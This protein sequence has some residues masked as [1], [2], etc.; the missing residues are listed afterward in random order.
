MLRGIAAIALLFAAGGCA[1][2][3]KAKREDQALI[4]ACNQDIRHDPRCIEL[5]TKTDGELEAKAEVMRAEE[6][7]EDDA[8]SARVKK[9]RADRDAMTSTRSAGVAGDLDEGDEEGSEADDSGSSVRALSAADPNEPGSPKRLETEKKPLALAV[10]KIEIPRIQSAVDPKPKPPPP[11]SAITPET[12]L[13]A[14]ICLLDSEVA[15]LKRAMNGPTAAKSARAEIALAIV[16]ADALAQKV[17]AE[18]D[19]RGLS[20][21]P[22]STCTTRSVADMVEVL[23]SLVGPVPKVGESA[24]PFARGLERLRR[25]LETRAGLPRQAASDRATE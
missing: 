19:H 4:D 5:L 7:R 9:L 22:A 10:P 8:F 11:E 25:E 18:V 16:D 1:S 13:R 17:R 6:A 21:T 3:A 12:Y 15:D 24:E 20:R 14:S 2:S 23:R